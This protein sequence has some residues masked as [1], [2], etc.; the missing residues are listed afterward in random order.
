MD[1]CQIVSNKNL[2]G[3]K[4]SS[5]IPSL[6]ESCNSLIALSDPDRVSH[7]CICALRNQ[8]QL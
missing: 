5:E 4:Q 6:P 1:A 8:M 3:V 2:D 7:V